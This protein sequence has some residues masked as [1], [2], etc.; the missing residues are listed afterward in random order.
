MDRKII[1]YVLG[2]AVFGF[3]GFMLLTPQERDDDMLRLPWLVDTDAQGR[4]Q[5]FGFTIGETTLSDVRDVFGEEGKIN[6]FSHPDRERR[7]SVEA[8]FDRIY[9]NGL[10]A[11]F[12]MTLDAGQDDLQAMYERGLRISQLGSGGKK[13]KLAPEDIE[14]LLQVPI[15]VIT[16]LPW[17]SLDA[18][19]V[20]KRFGK[21][22]QRLIEENG[23]AHWLY[24]AK[25]MDIGLDTDGGVVIQY[26]NP[27]AFEELIA[28]LKVG[29]RDP[30]LSMPGMPAGVSPE[31]PQPSASR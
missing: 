22:E 6:L 28:P 15:R 11:D 18:E 19:I 4:T 26:L 7:Y 16:Y 9:L 30:D 24:P 8:Y 29:S 31:S 25:G 13:V 20:E 14:V 12:V 5:V 27:P 23:V 3:I 1:L 10:R 21:P 17:K 2:A